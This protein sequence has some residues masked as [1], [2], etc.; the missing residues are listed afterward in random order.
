MNRLEL[1]ILISF[2]H[3]PNHLV[4]FLDKVPLKIFSK[5][6]QRAIAIINDLEHKNALSLNAFFEYLS[7]KEKE[8]EYFQELLFRPRISYVLSKIL[9]TEAL[10][11]FSS[12]SVRICLY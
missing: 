2:I 8:S 10:L 1:E 3:Y 9:P 5:E 12:V 11:W 6:A 4:D 7:Q